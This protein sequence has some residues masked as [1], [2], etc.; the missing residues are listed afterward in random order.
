MKKCCYLGPKTG[1]HITDIHDSVLVVNVHI[2][3]HDAH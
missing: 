3:L 1:L 2:I